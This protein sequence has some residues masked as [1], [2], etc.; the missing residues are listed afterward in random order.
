MKYD[1]EDYVLYKVENGILHVYTQQILPNMDFSSWGIPVEQ[2]TLETTKKNVFQENS[3]KNDISYHI[4]K[5]DDRIIL[6]KTWCNNSA[7]MIHD[8]W[9]PLKG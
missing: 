3:R 8:K 7:T 4:H 2:E 9:L 1:G 6:Q 5:R